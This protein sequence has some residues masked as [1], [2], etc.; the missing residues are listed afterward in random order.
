MYAFVVMWSNIGIELEVAAGE[1]SGMYCGCTVG[2]VHI[3]IL[4]SSIGTLGQ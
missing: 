3:S 1:G 4:L 2:F